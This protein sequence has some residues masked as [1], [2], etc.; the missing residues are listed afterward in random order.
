[1][2]KVVFALLVATH[3]AAAQSVT[4]TT[5]QA[6]GADSLVIGSQTIIVKKVVRVEPDG[7]TVMHSG[8]ISKY[9]FTELPE[10]WQKKYGYDSKAASEY[11]AASRKAQTRLAAE[12]KVIQGQLKK[13]ND[14]ALVSAEKEKDRT[15]RAKNATYIDGT[16]RKN[17]EGGVI[18]SHLVYRSEEYDLTSGDSLGDMYDAA[19]EQKAKYTTDVPVGTRTIFIEGVGP[20]PLGD[21]LKGRIFLVDERVVDGVKMKVFAMA[22]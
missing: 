13:K 21:S 15:E 9:F 11:S 12:Q 1:M 5:V 16:V 4:N 14:A 22:P 10:S 19:R 20:L 18:V 6:K 2:K 3:V 7:I 17:V 8:G